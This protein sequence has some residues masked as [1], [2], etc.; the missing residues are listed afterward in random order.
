MESEDG[1]FAYY[2]KF[3]QHGL[4][5]MPLNGGKE[6][7]VWAELNS[8]GN[9]MLSRKGIYFIEGQV[10]GKI[11]FFDF[12]TRKKTLVAHVEKPAVGLALAPDAKTLFFS[13]NESEVYEIML[14]KNFY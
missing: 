12:Y 5:R 14:V 4:W 1:R 3:N 6:K 13:R 7:R 8:G 9:W 10:G 2:R 11:E